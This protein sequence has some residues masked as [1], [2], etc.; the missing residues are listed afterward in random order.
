MHRIWKGQAEPLGRNI[1]LTQ[2]V[3]VDKC[4]LFK[5]T[6]ICKLCPSVRLNEV[7]FHLKAVTNFLWWACDKA[8][9][10]TR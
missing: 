3:F 10:F 6:E 4:G 2:C 1:D 9:M 5:R 8:A 7:K